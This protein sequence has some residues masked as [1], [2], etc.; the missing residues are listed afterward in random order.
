MKPVLVILI[1]FGALIFL[2][3]AGCFIAMRVIFFNPPAA[4]RENTKPDPL[5]GGENLAKVIKQ[6][7]AATEKIKRLYPYK[8]VSVKT[9]DGLTL[10]GDFYENQRLTK[11]TFLCV[12]G[13]NSAG[14]YEFATM[15]EPILKGGYNCFLINQRKAPPSEGKHTGFGVLEKKDLL[16]WI[17]ALNSLVPDGRIILYGVSMGGAT[18]MQAS[19]FELKNVV[20]IIEDCGYTS[21]WEEFRFMLK[22]VAHLPAFPI[23]NVI[24]LLCKIFLKFDLK[25]S[26]S[27][28]AVAK[29]S[30]PML[31]VHGDADAFVPEDMSHECYEACQGKKQ[32]I[33]FPKAAHAQSH[34]T[35]PERYESALLG[36]AD[37]CIRS[38]VEKEK[39]TVYNSF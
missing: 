35:H 17:E 31:F 23:L 25:S 24:N 6:V 28:K 11:N 1:F 9:D 5:L 37:E 38:A 15:V 29:T 18:V 12:H 10:Y 2:L 34:F 36:F 22:T 7:D 20:G 14:Y 16:K 3:F 27:R 26:D 32:I 13:Y 39:E 4:D 30:L 33:I 21:C 19:E 8:T